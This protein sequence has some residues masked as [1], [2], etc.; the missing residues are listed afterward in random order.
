MGYNPDNY[1]KIREEYEG[2]P[3][4]ARDAAKRREDELHRKFETVAQI[5]K[6]LSETSLKIYGESLKGRAGI[7][8]RIDK[9]REENAELRQ[10]RAQILTANGYP[11]DYSSVKYECPKCGDTGFVGINMCDCLKKRLILAGYES[12]GIGRLIKTQSFETFDLEKCRG[13]ER[14]YENMKKILSVCRSFADTFEPKSG[15]NLLFMGTTGLG[16]THLS[17]SVAKV[18]I[19]RGYDVVY[20]TFQNILN[21]F[22]SERF[23]RSSESADRT[24]RYYGCD[25]LIIDDLGAEL[26]NQFTISVLYN[27]LNT[28]LNNSASMIINTNLLVKEIRDRYNDRIT[29]RLYGE[30]ES[31]VFFGEDLRIKKKL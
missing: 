21:D 7:D 5:D 10:M 3:Q 16:K 2:K 14:Q 18:V 25:L 20:D 17:T 6:L 22:E 19:E 4:R 15:K 28:R 12:S 8:E 9:L 23:G 29:S 1:R 26:T 11:A 13:S 30:F 31:Y 24:R 27:L